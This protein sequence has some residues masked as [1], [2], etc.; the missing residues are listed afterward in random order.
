MT[1][2]RFC[3]EKCRSRRMVGSATVMIA[4]PMK[5]MYATRHK[6]ASISWPLRVARNEARGGAIAGYRLAPG[7]RDPLT[8]VLPDVVIT[9][10]QARGTGLGAAVDLIAA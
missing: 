4:K 7:V 9:P 2:C 10:A 3:W 6:K 5:S 8:S 1:H